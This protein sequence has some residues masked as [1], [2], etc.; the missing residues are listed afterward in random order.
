[1]LLGPAHN[2][3]EVRSSALLAY[4]SFLQLFQ[5]VGSIY[6]L[7]LLEMEEQA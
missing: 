3:R 5:S 4:L 6:Q 2:L 7:L 1:M